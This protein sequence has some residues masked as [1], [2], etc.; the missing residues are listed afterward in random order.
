MRQGVREHLLR[1]G[2]E[3]VLEDLVQDFSWHRRQMIMTGSKWTVCM[4]VHNDER[5]CDDRSVNDLVCLVWKSQ[6]REAVIY[7][8]LSRPML[9]LTAQNCL[10]TTLPMS[11]SMSRVKAALYRLMDPRVDY[12]GEHK[13]SGPHPFLPSDPYSFIAGQCDTHHHVELSVTAACGKIA[14][15]PRQQITHYI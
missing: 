11:S 1:R 13:T 9:A 6:V 15:Y 8:F 2:L 12:T 14:G 3:N 10:A 7:L 4:I 5:I